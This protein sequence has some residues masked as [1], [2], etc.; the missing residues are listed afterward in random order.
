MMNSLDKILAACHDFVWDVNRSDSS[1]KPGRQRQ[2]SVSTA[3]ASS[4][5][6]VRSGVLAMRDPESVQATLQ[7]YISLHRCAYTSCT[8]L[9]IK[10]S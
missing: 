1:V 7:T 3:T 9:Y 8:V 2:G 6:L 10:D 5:S 4:D